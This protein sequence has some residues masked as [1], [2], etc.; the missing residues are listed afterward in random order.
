MIVGIIGAGA[1]GTALAI[2]SARAGND[3]T[4]W[5]YDG[6]MAEFEGVQAP[7]QISVTKDMK[8]LSGA[9]VWLIVTPA[10][11]FRET[12]KKTV[13]VY[14]G[15]P[16]IVCTKGIEPDTH[17]FMSE[18]IAEE[19]PS[20]RDFGVLSGPQFAAEVARR[21][22]TGSTLAGNATT[23]AAGRAALSDLYI[24]ESDDI[25]GAEVCGV[26]KNAVAL[27]SGYAGIRAAGENEKAMTLTRAWNEVVDFGKKLGAR[28]E[29]FLKLCG[30]GDL[31][32]S[33]TSVTSRNYSAG[34][35]IANGQPIVGTVEGISA[36]N[37]IVARAG[38][39][40]IPVLSE[41]QSIINK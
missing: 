5:S 15:Q 38:D 37:G 30:L 39:T 14:A 13:D 1:W 21:I 12:V 11:H 23:I 9:D 7:T 29:T 3:I 33:A 2:S 4:L 8:D 25:I 20:C 28:D 18:I 19:L 6:V 27:I 32:L 36:L 17:K 41:M 16:I 31:F 26:G 22:P 35:A 10:K 34:V 40:K 24:E